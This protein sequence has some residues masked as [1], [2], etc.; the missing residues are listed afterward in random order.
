MPPSISPFKYCCP[1]L[2]LRM[3][4]IMVTM[5]LF[6]HDNLK[7]SKLNGRTGLQGGVGERVVMTMF[8]SYSKF[9]GKY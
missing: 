7:A 4:K 6:K 1:I 9:E 2:P 3:I 5:S 8:R